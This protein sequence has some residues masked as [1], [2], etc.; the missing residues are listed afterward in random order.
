VQF[1][2]LCD[3]NYPENMQITT[4]RQDTVEADLKAGVYAS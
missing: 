3:D 1:A 2:H 4:G